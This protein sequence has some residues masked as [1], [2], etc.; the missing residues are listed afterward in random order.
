MNRHAGIRAFLNKLASSIQNRRQTPVEISQTPRKASLHLPESG[1][2]NVSMNE[3]YRRC[4][5][6][7]FGVGL[8]PASGRSNDLS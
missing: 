8:P 3:I 1:Q 5:N 4:Y 6:N 2:N 7:D